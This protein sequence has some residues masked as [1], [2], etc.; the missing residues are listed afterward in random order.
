MTDSFDIKY[1]KKCRKRLVEY[2]YGLLIRTN[3]PY[4]ILAFVLKATHFFISYFILLLV[5][6][7]PLPVC[8]L[9]TCLS[10]LTFGLFLYF[11]GCFLSQL[12]YKLDDKDFINI[13]DLYLAIV[14]WDINE[15]NRYTITMYVVYL[16]FATLFSILY[17]RMNK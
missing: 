14:G 13:V 10:I 15:E 8:F 12:E 11:K 1:R 5:I 17:W 16:Y 9:L 2:L 6:F 7:M 3:I 4:P